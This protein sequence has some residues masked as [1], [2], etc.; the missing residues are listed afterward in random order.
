VAG[1]QQHL[2]PLNHIEYWQVVDAAMLK[3]FGIDTADAGIDA[4]LIASAQEECQI[5]EDF[6]RWHGDKDDLT[7]LD[8]WKVI[9]GY[10]SAS[11][12]K[13]IANNREL[14]PYANTRGAFH[15]IWHCRS[16]TLNALVS[17]R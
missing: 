6:A 16:R 17:R 4:D 12:T 2:A 11:K 13:K 5:A 8:E 7:Y 9:F 10:R 3:F 15:L 1:I 14:G